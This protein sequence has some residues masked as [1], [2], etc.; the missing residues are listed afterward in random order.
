LKTKKI[1]EISHSVAQMGGIEKQ[2]NQIK[3]IFKRQYDLV[4][5]VGNKHLADRLSGETIDWKLNINGG[6][7]FLHYLLFQK[8]E[9]KYFAKRIEQLGDNLKTVHIHSLTEQ[10]LLTPIIKKIGVKVVWTIHGELILGK[11]IWLKKI[12]VKIARQAD[13][14]ICVTQNT[15]EQVKKYYSEANTVVIYNGV[16]VSKRI[17]EKKFNSPLT[18][19]F[20]GRLGTEKNFSYFVQLVNGLWSKNIEIKIQIAGNKID[21]RYDRFLNNRQVKFCGYLEDI[22]QFY[23]QIDWLIFPSPSEGCP[24]A[25]LEAMTSGVIPIVSPIKPLLE[26]IQDNY[27]GI[28]LSMVLKNDIIKLVEL[29]KN[30]PKMLRFSVNAKKTTANY[31]SVIFSQNLAKIYG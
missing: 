17:S 13:Q 30:Q 14:I 9:Q 3:N 10:L 22:D 16:E 29:I 5:W 19:G 23:R 1:L 21:N 27:T 18:V 31:S 8:R 2:L 4:F 11:N 25:L 26:I 15:Q 12:F 28:V 7:A 24:Y 6:W 20:V